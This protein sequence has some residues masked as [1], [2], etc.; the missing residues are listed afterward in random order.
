MESL[1][2]SCVLTRSPNGFVSK[3]GNP[4]NVGGFLL[5]FLYSHKPG[6]SKPKKKARHT[7]ATHLVFQEGAES[8]PQVMDYADGG[9]LHQRITRTRQ[10][11]KSFS[12]DRIVRRGS[13]AE[14]H[15]MGSLRVQV[16]FLLIWV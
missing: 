8:E 9:D 1:F 13:G 3:Y 12:E 6:V 7:P 4:S 11:G 5:V 10:A 16:A 14:T 2:P 15:F